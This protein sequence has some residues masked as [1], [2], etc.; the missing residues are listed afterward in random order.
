MKVLGS[1]T[2]QTLGEIGKGEGRNSKVYLAD[3]PQL[4]GRVAVK[5]IDKAQF[6]SSATE[7]FKEAQAM[8]RT[9]HENVVPIHYAC[10]TPTSISLVMPHYPNGS[11]AKRISDRP[12]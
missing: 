8:Y 11:L 2:Y 10:Q 1:I 6:G 7:Y 4:G 12:L 5:E 9:T 3:E